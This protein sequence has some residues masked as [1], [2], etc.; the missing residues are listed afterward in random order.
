MKDPSASAAKWA[1]NLAGATQ[2]ITDGVNRV[3]VAPGQKAAAQKAVW[4]A[5]TTAAADKFARNVASVS[6]QTWQADMTNKGIP[7]I[8]SGAQAAQTKMTAFL[9]HFLPFVDQGVKSLPPRGNLQQNIARATSMINY[10]AG[11]K[12]PAGS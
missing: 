3:T 2:T 6:L 11:Y 10:T 1:T 5:N 9:T 8:A 12:R 4:M 7:R